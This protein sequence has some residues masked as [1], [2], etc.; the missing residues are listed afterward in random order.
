MIYSH[1]LGEVVGF[2]FRCVLYVNCANKNLQCL[3]TWNV[4][5]HFL[6]SITLCYLQGFV[7]SLLY[8]FL[9]GEVWTFLWRY[10]CV[11]FLVNLTICSDYTV[12]TVLQHI[13]TLYYC[14][15][16]FSLKSSIF[17]IIYHQFYDLRSWVWKIG[18]CKPESDHRCFRR[19]L[20]VH[21]IQFYT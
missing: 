1:S 5:L 8:C 16:W 9:N 6:S 11:H 19:R 17:I 3:N 10:V 14:Y 18:S 20:C 7:V 4:S 13:S 12:E 2:H 15:T 21:G